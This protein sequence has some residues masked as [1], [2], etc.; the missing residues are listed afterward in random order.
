MILSGARVA[1]SATQAR[2]MDIEIRRGKIIELRPSATAARDLAGYLIL[3][4]LINAHEHLSFN[5]F[6]LLGSPPYRNAG[7]WARDVYRPDEP[8]VLEH[9]SVP[10]KVRLE[11]GALKNLLSGVTTVGHHDP[12]VIGANFPVKIAHAAWAHSLEFT[13]DIAKRHRKN[14]GDRPFVVHLGEGT[15]AATAAEIFKAEASGVIDERTVIVHGVALDAKGWRLLRRLKASVITCPVSNLFT[16]G[17]TLGRSAFSRGVTIALGTDS[18]LTA[19]GDL[20]DALRAARSV[21]KLSAA[22]LYRMVLSDAAKVLRSRNGEGEIREG[23]VADLIMVR[24]VG[25]SPAETLLDLRRVEMVIVGGKV[26]MVSDRGAGMQLG[27]RVVFGPGRTEYNSAAGCK[28]AQP[29]TRFQRISVEGRGRVW[30][31]ADVARLYEEATTRLGDSIKLA[32]RWV[33]I[34]WKR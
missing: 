24:D 1:L 28:L 17:R 22:R 19:P 14:R 11:W 5:L 7:E 33:R 23:G 20:L 21:W 26:K 10:R 3:P 32:G 25:L 31:D 29:G 30:V 13:P 34:K 12:D 18:G 4:G 9:R 16:L 6:P 8:P 2:R 27:R 15:D